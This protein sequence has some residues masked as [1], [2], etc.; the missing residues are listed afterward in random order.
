MFRSF[1]GFAKRETMPTDCAMSSGLSD[2]LA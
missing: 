2:L 1:V